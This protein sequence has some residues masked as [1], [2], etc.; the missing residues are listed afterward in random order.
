MKRIDRGPALN[1]LTDTV[2]II[3]SKLPKVEKKAIADKIFAAKERRRPRFDYFEKF[4][5]EMQQILEQLSQKECTSN[6]KKEI[7]EEHNKEMQKFIEK[8]EKL[9][10][11]HPI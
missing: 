10:E 8:T 3:V 1:C 5:D 11:E 6:V 7:I 9:K 4:K 2:C